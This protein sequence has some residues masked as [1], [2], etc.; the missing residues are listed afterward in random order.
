MLKSELSCCTYVGIAQAITA[1]D[2]GTATYFMDWS[3]L[4]RSTAVTF[5]SG[6]L[7]KAPGLWS[8]LRWLT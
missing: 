5:V 1:A 8:V 4:G 2:S 7:L 6:V 3:R